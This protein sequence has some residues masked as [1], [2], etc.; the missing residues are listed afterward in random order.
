MAPR[1]GDQT[2]GPTCSDRSRGGAGR[3]APLGARPPPS[4]VRLACPSGAIDR[5]AGARSART[6]AA[7]CGQAAP[8]SRGVERGRRYAPRRGRL[9]ALLSKRDMRRYAERAVSG[10]EVLPRNGSPKAPTDT[11]VGPRSLATC[12]VF[13]MGRA[14]FDPPT[15]GLRVRCSGGSC[16]RP[17]PSAWR[18]D[19]AVSCC[20]TQRA[21]LQWKPAR[22][23]HRARCT[24]WDHALRKTTRRLAE[25]FFITAD[26]GPG[27]SSFGLLN[28]SVDHRVTS[29]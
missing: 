2:G 13:L 20:R 4:P 5:G 11:P 27:I 28:T 10:E 12:R 1:P 25:S 23:D 9:L 26:R 22:P 21:H 19:G 15:D 16:P 24:P 17:R 29:A 14:G 8:R 7:E 18:F 3:R 6:Q